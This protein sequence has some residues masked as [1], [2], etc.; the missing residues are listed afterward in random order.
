MVPLLLAHPCIVHGMLYAPTSVQADSS[1]LSSV[2][3]SHECTH[4]TQVMEYCALGS[5]SD[6]IGKD[7]DEVVWDEAG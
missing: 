7:F 5:V 4:Y 1:P 6:H 3:S 2:S